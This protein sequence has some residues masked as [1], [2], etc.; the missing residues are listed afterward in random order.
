MIYQST[1]SES[2]KIE[3]MSEAMKEAENAAAL[4]EVPIGCVIVRDKTIISRG[5]NLREATQD[6]TTHAE[7][8]AIRSANNQLKSF[9]LEECALFV[10]VE[11]CI[12]CAGG[13][14]L[15]RIPE[16]YFGASNNKGG[17][18]GS[19][20]DV[21]NIKEVNHAPY[22]EGGVLA[23]RSSDLMKAFFKNRRGA[24]KRNYSSEEK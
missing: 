4:G 15:S 22:I 21:M 23:E 3:F 18:C 2:E 24:N 8:T 12:M 19:V 6:A 20:I 16:V 10:T 5:Y 9:R 11:P 17:A 13:I 14:L 1:F 7:I